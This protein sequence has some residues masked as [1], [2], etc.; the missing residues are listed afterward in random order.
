[1]TRNDRIRRNRDLWAR[2]N[3]DV[4]DADAA[5]RWAADQITWGL[6]ATPESRVGVLGDVSG[7]DVLDLACGTGYFSAWLTKR[8]ARVTAV[9]FSPEQLATA[10]RCQSEFGVRFDLIEANA[11]SLPLPDVSFDLVVSEHGVGVWCDPEAWIGEAARVMRPRG[12][13]LFLVNSVI[14]A[15]CVPAEGGTAGFELLRGQRDVREVTWPGGGT[16]FHLS[17]GEWISVLRRFGFVVEQLHELYPDA[18][19][20]PSNYA[21]YLDIASTEWASRWP[22]EELWVARHVAS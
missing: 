8:G 14:S 18:D 12:R 19:V 5:A 15:L 9:D 17:H 2:V 3:A 6:T 22:V 4:T 21:D 1:M 11:E 7:L 20:K 10:R 13:L 16:E